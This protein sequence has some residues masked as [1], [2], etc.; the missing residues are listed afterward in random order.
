MMPQF[1]GV[2]SNLL[3]GLRKGWTAVQVDGIVTDIAG[4]THCE[5]RPS[6]GAGRAWRLR[7]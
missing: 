7:I 4:A 6:E 2:R 3:N 5:K 1:R